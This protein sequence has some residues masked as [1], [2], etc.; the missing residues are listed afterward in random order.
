MK[1]AAPPLPTSSARCMREWIR[2]AVLR[3]C[4]MG[5]RQVDRPAG[6]TAAA[7]PVRIRPRD[8]Q[9]SLGGFERY[10]R[11]PRTSAPAGAALSGTGRSGADQAR[12][13]WRRTLA[14]GGD[15]GDTSNDRQ[16]CLNGLVRDRTPH[17]A[18]FEAQRAQQLFRFAST[19][20]ADADRHQ[21]LPVPPHRQR[22]AQLAAGAGRRGARQRQL[23][24][25]TPQAAIASP[26]SI[27]CRCCISPASCG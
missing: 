1:A 25:L 4:Q 11:V 22:A 2:S 12:R 16:F 18:L 5:A 27:A 10:W 23:R 26:C 15:F 9:Q 3:R 14:Y 21:R 13:P 17:P 8:G 24:S 6:G 20:L 19:P 7:D